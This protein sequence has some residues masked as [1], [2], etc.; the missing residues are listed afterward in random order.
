MVGAVAYP[1]PCQVVVEIDRSHVEIDHSHVEIDR[2]GFAKVEDKLRNC[3]D[4]GMLDDPDSIEILTIVVARKGLDLVANSSDLIEIEIHFDLRLLLPQLPI[5]IRRDIRSS[6]CCR[7]EVLQ[8]SSLALIRL[9]QLQPFPLLHYNIPIAKIVVAKAHFDDHN[10]PRNHLQRTG[11]LRPRHKLA[12]LLHRYLIHSS[13]GGFWILLDLLQRL[14]K[15]QPLDP[16][17]RL[18]QNQSLYRFAN[19]FL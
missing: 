19:S 12:N 5:R 15:I 16:K 18:L 10:L 4:F 13:I 6:H 3:I 7:L 9:F 14:P 2:K 17:R 8:N 1:F 11:L